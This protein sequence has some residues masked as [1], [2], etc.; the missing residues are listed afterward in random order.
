M[1]GANTIWCQS[2]DITGR[3]SALSGVNPASL[4]QA[5]H[6]ASDLLYA[7]SGRRFPGLAEIQVRPTARPRSMT[8]RDW[9]HYLQ[10]LSG[11]G[12]SIAW[13]DGGG[14]FANDVDYGSLSVQQIDLGVYPIRQI[15]LVKINGA[16]I[17]SDEYRVDDFRYLV[18]TTSVSVT[19]TGPTETN[20]WP[21][22][23]NL[24][25][26]D[27]EHGT[28]SVKLTYG[29]DPPQ[30]GVAA[31]TTMATEFARLYSGAANRLPA[32]IQ[33]IT[34]QGVTM[35]IIDPM[36]FLDDGL[37]GLYDVDLFIRQYNRGKQIV[38][39][40]IW[41]PDLETRRRPGTTYP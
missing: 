9:S 27:T 8:L 26:P 35:A 23:Q 37:T 5:C 34:R 12:T 36:Q 10:T 28:F 18:R 40:T 39:A 25:L 30:S 19:S 4:I 2:S 7:A 13:A 3:D 16:I 32:R 22:Q 1:S 11:V 14:W 17:P 15:G 41:S 6:S 24:M 31:A 33:S 21:K 20:G 38:P 29:E